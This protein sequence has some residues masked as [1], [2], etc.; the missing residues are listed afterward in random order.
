MKASLEN[1]M[2]T[3]SSLTSEKQRLEDSIKQLQDERNRQNLEM[4]TE[5]KNLQDKLTKL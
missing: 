4:K 2:R 1:L 5:I 3:V